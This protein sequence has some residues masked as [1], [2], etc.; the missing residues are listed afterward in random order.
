[1]KRIVALKGGLGNQM[2]QYSLY[3]K[4]K[5]DGFDSYLDLS[6]Y[7]YNRQQNKFELTMVFDLKDIDYSNKDIYKPRIRSFKVRNVLYGKI[8]RNR[9]YLVDSYEYEKNLKRLVGNNDLY[10]DGY[11]QSSKY[12]ESVAGSIRQNFSFSSID[13]RNVDYSNHLNAVNSISL[14]VRRGDYLSD[15]LH[16]A[17]CTE[18]YYRNAIDR[19][20]NGIDH[21]IFIVFSDDIHWCKQMFGEKGNDFEYVDWNTGTKSYQDMFLMTRC[22]HNII[23]NSSFSWWG[24]WLNTNREKIVIAPKRWLNSK[25]IPYEDVIP[26]EWVSL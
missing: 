19:M 9:N 15:H 8:L 22:K 24:A 6:W 23:A 16:Q 25:R 5:T 11:W 14:H 12:F 17:G 13:P 4:L 1:M 26:K 3:H 18:E 20:R 21:P 7:E 2:F 10:C